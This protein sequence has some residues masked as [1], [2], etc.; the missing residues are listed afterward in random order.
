VS[1]AA[2]LA[3]RTIARA[4]RLLKEIGDK[5]LPHVKLAPAADADLRRAVSAAQRRG[6]A[7][8]GF[9]PFGRDAVRTAYVLSTRSGFTLFASW[10]M[11]ACFG[12]SFLEILTAPRTDQERAATTA[13]IAALSDTLARE[14]VVSTFTFAPADDV[15]L[16]AV[17]LAN[18]FR[19]SAVLA[20]H[21]T[22]GAE[23][24]DAIL[25][26]KKLCAPDS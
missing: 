16:A 10:E 20:S 13:A 14:K 5:P 17:F 24:K 4:R 12:N 7:L 19:R 25:W 3:D 15:M 6:R 11:Q 8:T 9:E 26:S 18:G 1:P 2:A 21:M 22:V 23:R